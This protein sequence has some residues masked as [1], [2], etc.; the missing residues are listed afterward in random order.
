M[1][2]RWWSDAFWC[3]TLLARWYVG[4]DY[5]YTMQLTSMVILLIFFLVITILVAMMQFLRSI[6]YLYYDDDVVLPIALL[7]DIRPLL[8]CCSIIHL[9]RLHL[10]A[11]RYHPSSLHTFYSDAILPVLLMMVVSILLIDGYSISRDYA[12]HA[13]YSWISIDVQPSTI[14]CPLHSANTF[15][16]A[17][18]WHCC[19]QA[20]C[21]SSSYFLCHCT[22]AC[23]H[24]STS[25]LSCHLSCQPLKG[26]GEEEHCTCSGAGSASRI[27]CTSTAC[28][29]TSIAHTFASILTGVL[30]VAAYALSHALPTMAAFMCL[31]GSLI[32]HVDQPASLT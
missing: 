24:S 4:S 29:L 23:L 25:H 17:L 28:N 22:H 26:R 19:L 3:T 27:R 12:L 30:Y 18:T 15:L 16:T 21:T 8:H 14:M 10:G 6:W 9:L 1:M 2:I 5:Y 31:L 11:W 20:H 13:Y 7:R 32:W